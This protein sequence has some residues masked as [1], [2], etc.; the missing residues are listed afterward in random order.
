MASVDDTGS[1]YRAVASRDRRFEGRFVVAVT[2]TG[3]YCR[4]GCPSRTPRRE[5]VRFYPTAA[6]AEA[7]GFRPCRRCHPEEGAASGDG[8]VGR[9][10]A[11]I[12]SGAVDGEGVAGT[13]RRLGVSPRTLH[14][15]LTAEV[16][17]RPALL[18]RSRRV[19][20]A[21]ALITRTALPFTEIAFAAGFNSLRSFNEAIRTELGASPGRLRRTGAGGEPAP[22][23][24][25]ATPPPA[26]WVTLRLAARSPFAAAP[27]LAFLA[28][29]ALPG[30][31]EGD[32]A[33]YAR[34][35]RT[36][37]GCA[38]VRLAPEGAHVALRAR[39]D[40]LR[41]LEEVVRRSR[42]L[43]DL[44]VDPAAVDAC[45]S[46]DRLLA[47]LVAAAPGLRV[48]RSA[49]PFETAV[50]TV[51]GQQVSVPGAR[52]IA[53]RLA[54]RYGTALSEPSGAVTRLFPG[55]ERLAGADLDGLGLT[56]ARAAS[57][58]ALSRAVV[59]GDLDLESG[60]PDEVDAVLS[61]LPGFGPWTRSAILM[62]ACADPDALPTSDLGLRRALERLGQPSDPRSLSR[63]AE[64][65]RPWRSY[66]TMHL[67]NSVAAHPAPRRRT[68]AASAV[69][70][71]EPGP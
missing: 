69:P 27:L 10:L 68:P 64:R 4:V 44:E 23:G 59:A 31:E 5:N 17:A 56:R 19:Q 71:T 3:V 41:D 25:G 62:R 58:R 28:V 9:V 38:L 26:G 70:T 24:G 51:I 11:L 22:A 21:H 6:A 20:T 36:R 42:R 32:G 16:G 40:D 57:I 8:M 13:A 63:H 45:L 65:W 67:W 34:S 54:G 39:L 14:R 61:R 66:A 55:P 60:P 30:V 53:G 29:R 33:T 50:R 7:A 12:A 48:P 49:E 46:G 37:H 1:R 52:T 2:S 35:L 43:L 47:P 15:R 18:A